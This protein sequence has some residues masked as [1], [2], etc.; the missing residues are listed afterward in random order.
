[1][2]LQCIKIDLKFIKFDSQMMDA[3]LFVQANRINRLDFRRLSLLN[4]NCNYSWKF[5]SVIQ[6]IFCVQLL[7]AMH[8]A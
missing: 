8:I 4:M 1:M 7:C 2:Y 6:L 5:F 3:K